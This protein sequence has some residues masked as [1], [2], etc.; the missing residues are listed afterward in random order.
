MSRSVGVEGDTP[1]HVQRLIPGD[2]G[3]R[4]FEART[5]HKLRER[6]ILFSVPMV[7]AIIEG[8]KTQTRRVVAPKTVAFLGSK[9]GGMDPA[10]DHCPYGWVGDRLWVRET[11][12][13]GKEWEGIP[14][15]IV[16][17]EEGVYYAADD[18]LR[19]G[20]EPLGKDDR[21]TWRRSIHMPR[22]ASRLTLE[23]TEVRVQRLQDITEEDARA[24]GIIEWK[25]AKGTAYYGTNVADVWELSAR[26]AFKRIWDDINGERAPWASNPWVWA[27]SFRRSFRRLP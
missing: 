17:D 18:S 10:E 22:W 5:G 24:E 9:A 14:P 11:Y 7:R 3:R 4:G 19:P 13:F 20:R 26:G 27:I 23:V 6:G 16:S 12:A 1:Q 21:G 8:R 25:D 15:R 2:E